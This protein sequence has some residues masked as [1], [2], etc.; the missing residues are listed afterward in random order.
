MKNETE[1]YEPIKIIMQDKFSNLG[2]C[3]FEITSKKISNAIK[4]KLDDDA[5][6]FM[7]AERIYPDLTGYVI[8]G[9][10]SHFIVAEVKHDKIKL[11]DIY[12]TKMYGELFHSKYTYLIS[13]KPLPEEIRR[14]LRKNP[15]LISYFAGYQKMT[16]AQF[17]IEKSTLLEEDI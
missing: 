14:F 17:D 9:R 3:Y 8:E 11:R 12:Q 13:S 16:I 2:E 7:N 15:A 10:I 5:L 1:L 6:F 4:S